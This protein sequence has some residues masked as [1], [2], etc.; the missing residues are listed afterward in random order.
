MAAQSSS[1]QVNTK[2]EA[3]YWDIYWLIDWVQV[4]SI[5]YSKP[6]KSPNTGSHLEI[7]KLNFLP[8]QIMFTSLLLI[9]SEP[10]GRTCSIQT[11][12]QQ[13]TGPIQRRSQQQSWLLLHF[14]LTTASSP[15][16]SHPHPSSRYKVL[17]KQNTMQSR[18]MLDFSKWNILKGGHWEGKV[19]IIW[20]NLIMQTLHTHSF[21]QKSIGFFVWLNLI[22]VRVV[23]ETPGV[24]WLLPLGSH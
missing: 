18:Q 5:W 22:V 11:P 8:A 21:D 1:V 23:S 15:T 16:G 14:S 2:L 19:K 20:L 9:K 17:E 12:P 7:K 13:N 6:W 3:N 10:A 24:V 4:K